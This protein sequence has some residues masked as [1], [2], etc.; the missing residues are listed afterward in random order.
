MLKYLT[1]SDKYEDEVTFALF[2]DGEVTMSINDDA[3]LLTKHQVEELI[4][5][6]GGLH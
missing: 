2:E 6:L 3:V 5:F 4:R 1:F